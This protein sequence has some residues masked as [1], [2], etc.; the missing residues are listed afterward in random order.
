MKIENFFQL[1]LSRSELQ[2]LAG[3]L[4]FIQ[5]PLLGVDPAANDEH[6]LV[7]A[8]EKLQERGLATYKPNSGWQVEKT[9]MVISQLIANPDNI[10]MLQTWD[11]SGVVGRAFAY[12]SQDFPLFV[13][14]LGD[15]KFT[16]H[17][18]PSGLLAQ[19]KAFFKLPAKATLAKKSFFVPN[20]IFPQFL[21]ITVSELNTALTKKRIDEKETASLIKFLKLINSV[22]V[23]TTLQSRY[24][25]LEIIS[26]KC[27]IWNEKNIF[28]GMFKRESQTT[29]LKSF[30]TS[31]VNKW[32]AG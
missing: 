21:H 31:G 26:Q 11:K 1:E 13:E 5:F 14:D 16:L 23:Q 18:R 27:M 2:L 10:L 8:Q 3:I 6:G 22:G 28:G 20:E 9:L 17:S 19:Q 32:L 30:T 12:P 24:G 15:L 29:E 4:G 7:A 25:D